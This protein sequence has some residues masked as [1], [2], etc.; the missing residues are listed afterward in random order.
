MLDDP[1]LIDF[2]RCLESFF[3]VII[4]ALEVLGERGSVKTS[5]EDFRD[6][7]VVRIVN[8]SRYQFTG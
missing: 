8:W 4:E 2:K 3:L 7:L 1:A 6:A 5:S